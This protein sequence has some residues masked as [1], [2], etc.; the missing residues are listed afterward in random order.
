MAADR[1][2]LWRY[3]GR[4]DRSTRR[5]SSSTASS[6]AATSWISGP[7]RAPSSS[8][9]RTGFD[10]WMLDWGIPDERDADNTFE[11]YVDEYLPARDRRRFDGRPGATEVTLVGLLPR[12]HIHDPLCGRA[13]GR[14]RPQP[15]AARGPDGLQR[16]GRNG[17]RRSRR[18]PRPRRARRRDRQ[19]AGRRA[20]RGVLHAGADDGDR[21]ATQRCSRTSGTTSSSRLAGD[22]AV[23]ARAGAVSGRGDAPGRRR[24]RATQRAHDGRGCS[25]TAAR[26]T[27]P[28]ARATCS[29]RS[30]SATRSSRSPRPSRRGRLV[31]APER[32]EELRLSGGHVTFFA[33]GTPRRTRCRALLEWLVAQRRTRS[34]RRSVMEIR[35]AR[36]G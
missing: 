2:E 36:D 21:A 28:R 23:V 24:A 6:A 5:S 25:W 11:T 10:V 14:G 31:G 34:A 4:P 12:R 18:P 29:T 33:A 19:R 35:Q 17:R 15:R 30:P 7:A 8:C 3:R 20:L 26:S 27:S 22:G 32:R 1:A 16:D 13:R 9:S